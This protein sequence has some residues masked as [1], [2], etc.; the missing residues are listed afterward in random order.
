MSCYREYP[1]ACSH[2]G[3]IYIVGGIGCQTIEIY[4]PLTKKFSLL[5][6]KIS[7][8]G[9]NCLFSYDDYIF[10]LKGD[11]L[12]K[13]ITKTMTTIEK[14]KVMHCDWTMSGD[15]FVTCNSC[16]FFFFQELFKLDIFMNTIHLVGQ[17]P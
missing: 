9:R 2:E 10:I 16:Y 17:I 4:S 12:T 5:N 11:T 8:P 15:S 13:F 7:S 6:L 14:S 1:G 3:K